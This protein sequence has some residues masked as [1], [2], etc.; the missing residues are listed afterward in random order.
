MKQKTILYHIT[1]WLL[2]VAYDLI[3]IWRDGGQNVRVTMLLQFSFCLSMASVF[4]YGFLFAYPRF[5]KKDKFIW[6]VPALLM[7]PVVFSTTRYLFE[8][9]LYPVLF[10]VSNYDGDVNLWY[11]LLDNLFYGVAV[12]VVSAAIWS[13]QQAFNQQE[14]NETLRKEKQQAELAFLQSQINPHFLYNTLNYIYSLAYPVSEPLADAIIKLS[15]LMRYTLHESADGKVDLQQDLDYLQNY[16]DIY[17]LRFEDRFFVDF[18]AEGDL[19]S[20]RIA[21]LMLI[22]FVE[23]AFKHGVVNDAQ[24][25]VKIHLKI[26]ANRLMVTVSNKINRNQKDQSSGIGLANTRRRLALIYPGR[27]ELLIADNG[28]SY[29]TTLNIDL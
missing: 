27:H 8:Q 24:R 28:Q 23:N 6:L 11:Y 9:I 16:I 25:P 26:I 1:G 18:K 5:L 10:N 20:K 22:P 19:T 17:R 14:E 21:S 7:V 13:A 29:K 2:V 4:Y 3:G 15:Q 12:T